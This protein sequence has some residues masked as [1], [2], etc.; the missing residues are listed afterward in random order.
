MIL[1]LGSA[2]DETFLHMLAALRHRA[3]AT[4]AM[5]VVQIAR[6]GT[7]NL[8]LDRP[9]SSTIEVG[10]LK[11]RLS[12]IRGCWIRLPD[13]ERADAEA[14]TSGS[15]TGVQRALSV[16]VHYLGAPV[17]NPPLLN[18]SNFSKPAHLLYLASQTG[19]QIPESC[20]TNSP[21]VAISFVDLHGGEIIYKGTSAHKTW[22]R[23]WKEDYDRVRLDLIGPTP[24]LFQKLIV[25]PDVRVHV[26]ASS[27]FAE[28]ICS[29][30][31]DYRT[32]A[33]NYYSKIECPSQIRE[34]CFLLS[35][36]MNCPLLGIDFKIEASTGVWILLEANP[37]P[38]FEGYDVRSGGLISNALAEYLDG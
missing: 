24:V 31:V 3:I 1:C 20:V 5:D 33:T 14:A 17:V 11:V 38:C 29:S 19:L 26:A 22:V 30:A 35:R 7:F 25:G 28:E 8:D 2:A 34:A 10:R 16:A 9:D 21:E 36:V 15:V 13:L 32:Q 12:E 4:V 18:P 6:T 23:R 37:M 27:I